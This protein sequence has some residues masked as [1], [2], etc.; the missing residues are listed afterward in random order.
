[1]Q[2]NELKAERSWKVMH[3]LW[4]S[5]VT[6]KSELL[7]LES[8]EDIDR[9]ND[10]NSKT[11]VL[12]LSRRTSMISRWISPHLLRAYFC[13]IISTRR[14][15]EEMRVRGSGC[16]LTNPTLTGEEWKH[17]F[18]QDK[19]SVLFFVLILVGY[20]L[21]MWLI[22][23]QHRLTPTSRLPVVS[24]KTLIG[25][26][27]RSA[28]SAQSEAFNQLPIKVINKHLLECDEPKQWAERR[29]NVTLRGFRW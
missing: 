29:K 2:P 25:L 28:T 11:V 20:T 24:Q 3:Y 21:L 16:Q 13:R 22:L 10:V 14:V 26:K 12:F 27:H 6:V 15:R 1:M 8:D 9:R 19:L 7:S 5:A 23:E 17:N 18:H 4:L